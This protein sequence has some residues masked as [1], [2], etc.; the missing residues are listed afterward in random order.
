MKKGHALCNI[1]VVVV[2]GIAGAGKTHVKSILL[3]EPPPVRRHSTPLAEEPARAMVLSRATSASGSKWKLVELEDY[4]KQVLSVQQ[5]V[6]SQQSPSETLSSPSPVSSGSMPASGEAPMDVH[7]STVEATE[8]C[9]SAML[10]QGPIDENSAPSAID[11]DLSETQKDN[12]V[13]DEDFGRELIDLVAKAH[14]SKQH[15]E[16]DWVYVIDSGGQVQFQQLLQLFIQTRSACLCVTKLNEQLSDCPESPYYDREERK[17]NNQSDNS[18]SNEDIL[19]R[20]FQLIQ[21]LQSAES[22][23]HPCVFVVGT[24][25]DLED[26]SKE[27][28][29]DKNRTLL[30]WMRPLFEIKL[31]MYQMGAEDQVIFPINAKTP[32]AADEKV[33]QLLR[34]KIEKMC[35]R[36]PVKIPWPWFIFELLLKRLAAK[37]GVNILTLQ[38]CEEAG[39]KLKMSPDDCQ[40]ALIFLSK[41][42]ILFYNANH[43]PGVVFVGSHVLLRFVTALVY[44]SYFLGTDDETD[45]ECVRLQQQCVDKQCFTDFRDRGLLST[46]LLD[47]EE[48]KR[49]LAFEEFK[50][51]YRKEVFTSTELFILMSGLH[52][53]API[54]VEGGSPKYIMPCVLKELSSE[55]G[56]KHR[57][58]NH[59]VICPLI[60]YYPERMLPL[61]V[62]PLLV[63]YLQKKATCPWKLTTGKGGKPNCIYFNCARFKLPSNSQERL[64]GTVTLL[65]FFEYMEI[66]V[67]SNSSYPCRQACPR[68]K[69]DIQEGL[70]EVTGILGYKNLP[71]PKY[72]IFCECGYEEEPH[73]AS[74]GE[75][76][77]ICTI[78]DAAGGTLEEKHKLWF[79]GKY[80]F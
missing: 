2:M 13:I 38:E 52:I 24:H 65:H 44:L 46:E 79:P 48:F 50:M 33:A 62:F 80:S 53:V 42:N 71:D 23:E 74:I 69:E 67:D 11:N 39:A 72:A 75:H 14:E 21:S 43:L 76:E 64:R 9:E 22:E 58:L 51:P 36:N 31:G 47:S 34:E 5:K 78:H 18:L 66:L 77:W 12:L 32:E 30:T 19:K 26:A 3:G 15:F 10:D 1:T 41:H 49:V 4:E 73:L 63:A 7:K 68:I 8:Y 56:C 16:V 35:K 59:S 37:H 20:Y 54:P 45:D 29:A 60:L 17:Y 61:G 70:K 40:A 25:K 27:S 57:Q 6:T 55:E 28:R